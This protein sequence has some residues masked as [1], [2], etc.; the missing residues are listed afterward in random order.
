MSDEKCAQHVIPEQ[1]PGV[2]Q[3]EFEDWVTTTATQRALLEIYRSV[4]S[5]K[6]LYMQMHWK[7]KE[8]NRSKDD[9][10]GGISYAAREFGVMAQDLGKMPTS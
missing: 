10:A 6:I 9:L 7:D 2:S 4:A 8:I 3:Y 5:A 1:T